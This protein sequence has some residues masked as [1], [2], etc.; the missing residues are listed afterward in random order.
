M[1]YSIIDN[2]NGYICPLLSSLNID[3]YSFSHLPR[4]LGMRGGGLCILYKS[5]LHISPL[6]DHRHV[7]CEAFSCSVSSPRS[8][9]FNIYVFY[10][11]PSYPIPPFLDEFNNFITNPYNSNIILGDFNIP[12]NLLSQYS[13]RLN[14]ILNSSNYSQL[15]NFPTHEL[16]NTLDLIMHPIDSN[17]VHSIRAGP[18]F[19]Y[20]FALL[21][22]ISVNKPKRPTISRSNRHLNHISISQF[23]T[24]L[25]TLPTYDAQSLHN[26]LIHTLNIIAPVLN[27]TTILRPNTSWYTIDLYRQKRCLRM[28]ESKWKKE[29]S[30]SSLT[31]YKNLFT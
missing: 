22:Q 27:K 20:H 1:D 19:S 4:S 9:T 2:N 25:N 11:S 31:I 18:L 15:V 7:Y 29:K 8:R 23:L 28:L 26:S 24:D 5:S 12:T 30:S 3:S 21:F 10:R 6:I 13:T 14:N 17:L 16:G